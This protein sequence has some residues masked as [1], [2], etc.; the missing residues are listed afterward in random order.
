MP[1]PSNA[2]AFVVA[3]ASAAYFYPVA[4]D[5]LRPHLPS[6][7]THLPYFHQP[8]QPQPYT[9]PNHTYTTQL[10]S[11][12]PLL[13][14]ISSF[15]TPLEAASLISLGTP[16]LTESPITGSGSD[17]SD[18]N[19][20][21]SSSAPLPVDDEVVSCV[22]AR[23]EAFL[24]PAVLK[25]GRDDMG[26]PQ[27]VRYTAG[28]RFDVHADWFSRPRLDPRDAERGRRRLYNRAATMFVVL[29][30]NATSGGETWFPKL[31]VPR[32]SSRGQQPYSPHPQGG[33]AFPPQAGNALFW[34]NLHPNGTGDPRVVHAGLPIADG[35]K[36]G[37][38]IWPRAFF[39]PD[40]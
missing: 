30:N 1:L 24:G 40:A 9:C 34:P 3:A 19:V 33:L 16:L 2:I 37:M 15:I 31:D 10:I 5:L 11:L 8:S 38:N 35:V 7:S 32:T 17:V 39:G 36:Y 21:T 26:S 23:A 29:E 22:L 20:R 6:L 4:F 25:A 14:Y 13:I 27:M 18:S 12:D 28:Q